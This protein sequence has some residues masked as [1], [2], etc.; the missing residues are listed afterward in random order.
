M[1]EFT[2]GYDRENDDIP[3]PWYAGSVTARSEG[4][5][6]FFPRGRGPFWLWECALCEEPIDSQDEVWV[7]PVTGN[8]SWEDG[9][10]YH[11]ECAP[12]EGDPI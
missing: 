3:R 12:E 11:M 7:E 1:V 4:K 2:D 6:W 9:W 10:P 8:T 5:I